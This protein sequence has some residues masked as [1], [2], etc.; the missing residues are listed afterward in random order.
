MLREMLFMK[1]QA[2]ALQSLGLCCCN[3]VRAAY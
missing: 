1:A 2:K 3:L